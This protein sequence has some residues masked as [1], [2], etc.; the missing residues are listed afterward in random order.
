MTRLDAQRA[1]GPG[2][3]PRVEALVKPE[4]PPRHLRIRIHH[5]GLQIYESEAD[6]VTS[7][8]QV[9]QLIEIDRQRTQ[10]S[11]FGVITGHTE[12]LRTKLLRTGT[13]LAGGHAPS[14]PARSSQL[15]AGDTLRSAGP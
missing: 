4:I 15:A 3:R 11:F 9:G 5:A 6:I 13:T 2:P 12:R 14:H 7:L 1:S 8:Q 10:S